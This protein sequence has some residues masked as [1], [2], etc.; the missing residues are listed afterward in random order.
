[1]CREDIDI[2]KR[3]LSSLT[4]ATSAGAAVPVCGPNPDRIGLYLCAPNAGV[5]TYSTENDVVDGQG[6][7]VDVASG[8]L[9]MRVEVFGQIVTKGWL[10]Q[11]SVG[12]Q[13]LGVIEVFDPD[14]K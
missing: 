12:A 6:V 9:M 13:G 3:S 1:M 2:G 8:G 11:G 14:A 5:A 10:V 4:P 7:N